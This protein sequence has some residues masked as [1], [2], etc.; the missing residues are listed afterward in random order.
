M[1]MENRGLLLNT[2]EIVLISAGVSFIAG[3]LVGYS[4]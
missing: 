4:L 1:L 3:F 2:I